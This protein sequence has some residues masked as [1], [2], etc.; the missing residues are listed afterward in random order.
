MATKA[1]KNPNMA[2]K[3]KDNPTWKGG[4]S[5]DYRRKLM[6][7][8]PGEVVHHKDHNKANNTKGNFKIEKPGVAKT[9]TGTR[10]VTAIGKHNIDHPEKGKKSIKARFY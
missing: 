10:R 2:R 7:A 3:G 9:S 5:S 8:K 6:G 4:K 1:K